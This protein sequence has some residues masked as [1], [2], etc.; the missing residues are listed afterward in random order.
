M[1]F[2]FLLDS[3]LS[4]E[5]QAMKRSLGL[6]STESGVHRVIDMTGESNKER[7][8]GLLNVFQRN[9][10]MEGV[11]EFVSSGSRF[12]IYL[13]RDKYIISFLLSSVQC[14]RPERRVPATGNSST[15]KIEQSE[16]FGPEALS[17]AKENFLQR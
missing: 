3:L 15:E 12:R 17:F 11:V 14:P 16:P 2:S 1:W 13:L 9:G 7:A 4:A 6:F 10:R 5:Q 8:K